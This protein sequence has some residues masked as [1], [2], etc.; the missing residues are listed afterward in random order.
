[1]HIRKM[2]CKREEGHQCLD[3]D[4]IISLYNKYEKLMR[5]FSRTV[6]GFD[7]DLYSECRIGLLKCANRFNFQEVHF[8]HQFYEYLH[9]LQVA[10]S[11]KE[12]DK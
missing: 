8:R 4:D 7:E 10:L 12:D 6:K 1:M 5:K 2:V 11:K 3:V 9:K